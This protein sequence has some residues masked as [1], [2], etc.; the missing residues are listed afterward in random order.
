MARSVIILIILIINFYHSFLLTF[1]NFNYLTYTINVLPIR[2]YLG[3]DGKTSI[4]YGFH[5]NYFNY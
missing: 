3:K 4:F 1:V 5:F 2:I